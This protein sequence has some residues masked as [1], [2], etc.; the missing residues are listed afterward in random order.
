MFDLTVS[1]F[2]L[3]RWD[4]ALCSMRI[5]LHL[6]RGYAS[7]GVTVS[8]G[9]GSK[10]YASSNKRTDKG[11]PICYMTIFNGKLAIRIATV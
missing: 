11:R 8:R 2:L 10:G 3:L 9:R 7:S 4:S 5:F 6:L 1:L